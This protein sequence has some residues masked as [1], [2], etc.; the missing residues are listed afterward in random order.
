MFNPFHPHNSAPTFFVHTILI[1]K[2][3]ISIHW[4]YLCNNIKRLRTK[5]LRFKM[6][7]QLTKEVL[8]WD[9]LCNFPLIGKLFGQR[10]RKTIF[11]GRN[12]DRDS[13]DILA[14]F[15]PSTV[16]SY[17]R[18]S[19]YNLIWSCICIFPWHYACNLWL[20]YFSSALDTYTWWIILLALHLDDFIFTCLPH[21]QWFL[22]ILYNLEW[23]PSCVKFSSHFHLNGWLWS[24]LQFL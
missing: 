5:M 12:R 7:D 24:S 20:K 11:I 15:A 9:H 18:I 17:H 13:V 1:V 6:L 10:E 14:T 22:W 21:V 16:P 8:G 4:D 3:T 19:K 23:Y 2:P